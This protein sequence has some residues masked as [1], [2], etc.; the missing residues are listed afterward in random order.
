M[1]TIEA[2]RSKIVPVWVHRLRLSR[3]VSD[4]ETEDNSGKYPESEHLRTTH[5]LGKEQSKCSDQANN[6]EVLPTTL[7]EGSPTNCTAHV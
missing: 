4:S 6:G 5:G 3:H 7:L 2:V 1:T